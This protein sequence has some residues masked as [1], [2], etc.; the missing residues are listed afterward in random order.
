MILPNAHISE[1]LERPTQAG[2]LLQAALL[3]LLETKDPGHSR[4]VVSA[5]SVMF[6]LSIRSFLRKSLTPLQVLASFF[7]S[8]ESEVVKHAEPL[9]E[10]IQRCAALLIP[11][12][13]QW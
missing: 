9:R 5:A 3:T 11:G 4:L 2:A 12:Y 7:M 6:L 1:L 13:M 8:A 10:L